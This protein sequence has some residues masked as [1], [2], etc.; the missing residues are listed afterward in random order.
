MPHLKALTLLLA[1]L[2]FPAA[3]S[4]GAQDVNMR[5]RIG[6]SGGALASLQLLA[7]DFKKDH[8][9]AAIVMVPSLGS[10]GG[11][12]ALLAG[13]IDLAVVSRPL[14]AAEREQGAMAADYARTPFVF[15]AA[16]HVK[17]AGISTPE[18]L[19]IYSGELKTW[20]S[21]HAL[22]LVLRP[23]AESDT[24]IVKSISP[25]MSRAVNTAHAREGMIIA[26][27]DKANADSL[28]TVHGAIGTTTLAQLIAEK[29]ALQPLALDGM[30]PSL[31][32]LDDG[33]YRYAKTFSLV[34]TSNPSLLVQQF[35][36]FVRS[37]AGQQI[38]EKN[39]QSKV[40]GK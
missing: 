21:G 22:R 12:K 33:S 14:K 35:I 16:A 30:M 1:L 31:Q 34:T 24:D 32:T 23:Q 40:P 9:A 3:G 28:E 38:L 4:A 2:I 7:E 11:I 29:R 19:G 26:P 8:P 25:A 20:P 39:G 5:L 10:G 6:G 37:S 15:A 27:T 36:A 17:A 13:A 18:L